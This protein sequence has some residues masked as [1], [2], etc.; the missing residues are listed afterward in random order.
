MDFSKYENKIEYVRKPSK[1]SASNIDTAQEA[2]KFA[3]DMV[4]YESKLKEYQEKNE[5]Y[6]KEQRR[7]FQQFKVDALE[8]VG[9]TNHPKSEQAFNLAYERGHSGGYSDVYNELLDLAD[10]LLGKA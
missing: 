10:L 5:Q 7:I 8:E 2:K 6:Q 4:I 3:D 9:L 1:P